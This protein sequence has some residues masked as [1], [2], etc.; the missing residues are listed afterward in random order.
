VPE[1]SAQNCHAEDNP[2]NSFP[3]PALAKRKTNSLLSRRWTITASV[4]LGAVLCIG[5][6]APAEGQDSSSIPPSGGEFAAVA[7]GVGAIIAAAIIV[8]IKISHSHHILAGCIVTGAHGLELQTSDVKA[9]SIEGDTAVIKAG[10]KVK[11]H[12]SKVKKAKDSPGPQVFKFEK[13]DRSYGP[14]PVA[15]TTASVSAH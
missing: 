8:P 13:L 7:I 10:E 5:A 1:T 6:S 4:V 3:F 15:A 9:Y 11:I 12:G 2:L 14:C